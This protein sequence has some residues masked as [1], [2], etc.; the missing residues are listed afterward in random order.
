MSIALHP[1]LFLRWG[2]NGTR[3]NVKT[4][5]KVRSK[6]FRRDTGEPNHETILVPAR[7]RS[8]GT[9]AIPLGTRL[10]PN[11]PDADVDRSESES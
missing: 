2:L 6:P 1:A 3:I 8:G 5:Q 7:S 4:G 11:L 10:D 9:A